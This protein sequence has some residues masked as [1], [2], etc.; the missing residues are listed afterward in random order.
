MSAY[1]SLLKKD[2]QYLD[3]I[4]RASRV[5]DEYTVRGEL[6]HKLDGD[7]KTW[8]LS[9]SAEYGKRFTQD[10]G[11]YFDPSVEL[12]IGRLNGKDYDAVSDYS[13]NKKLHVSQEAFNSAIGR[14]GF[15]IGQETEKANYFAKLALAHEFAG[16]ID[17]T[18]RADNE[19]TKNTH[20]DLGDT[21][22]ELELG[23]TAQL[24]KNT[25]L[26]GTY[27]RS[28]GAE[29]KTKWRADAGLRFTF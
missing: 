24:S 16:D 6:G 11:F 8:G 21:W 22:L 15:G 2:G 10:N 13:G 5:K 28:Y 20:I 12:T 7:Y 19:P 9:L 18:F 4:A 17:T 25:Y 3:L 29:V 23:G 1:G 14:I 26:Y 27:T